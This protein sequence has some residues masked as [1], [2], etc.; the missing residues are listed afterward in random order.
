MKK[1]LY[2]PLTIIVL[3]VLTIL[4]IFSLRR[5]LGKVD[6]I[7]ENYLN[8]QQDVTKHSLR[9][10]PQKQQVE[11]AKQPLAEEKTA[12]NELLKQKE[13]EYVL[14]IPKIEVKREAVLPEPTPRPV[15]KWQKLLGV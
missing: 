9:L 15:E 8:L 1:V 5:N 6:I 13:G 7:R 11:A 3:T 2:N 14:Y 12:R 10:E 4:I